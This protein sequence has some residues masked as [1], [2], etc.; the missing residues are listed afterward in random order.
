MLVARHERH[1]RLRL[2]M[3]ELRLTVRR[4]LSARTFAITAALTVGLAVGVNG[5]IYSAVRG[6]IV[7]PLPFR[8]ADRLVWIYGRARAAGAALEK[9][10][11]VEVNSLARQVSSFESVAVIGDRGF[12]RRD[13]ERRTRWTGIW[14]TPSLSAVL[15]IRPELGRTFDTDDAHPDVRLMMLG[16]ERWQRDFG[17]DPGIIGR[18]IRFLDNHEFTV[19]GILPRGLEFPFGR[20][21]QS[22][23]GSG[24]TL[25]VQDFWIVGQDSDVLPGGAAIARVGPD[26]TVAAARTEAAA[27]GTALAVAEPGSQAGRSLEPVSVRDQALG[28]V[29]P[30]LRLAQAF[31]AL[32]LLLACAN[33]INLTL[34]RSSARER[35]LGVRAA[36]GAGRR[37]IV[38]TVVAEVLLVTVAGAA[39]GLGVTVFAP[40][41]LRLLA[42]SAV[43]MIEHVTVD[44]AVV[45]FTVGVA[46]AVAL[47]VAVIP[48]AL[49]VRGNLHATL[50]SGGRTHTTDRRRARLHAGLVVSQVALALVLSVGAALIV[51]SFRRLMAVDAGYDPSGVIAADVTLHDHPQGRE[52]YRQLHARLAAVPGVEAVGMIQS[53]PLTGKWMF[54]DPFAVVGRPGDPGAAPPVSG[55]FIAFDYFEA[56]HTPVVLGRAFTPDEY[57]GDDAPALIINETAARRFFPNASPLGESAFLAGKARRIVGVVKDMRDVRLDTPADAQWFQPL[58]FDGTQLVIRTSGRAAD[59]VATIRRELAAADSRFEINSVQPLDDIV[60]TTVVERRMAMRLL[61]TLAA[62]ALAL[63]S[64]GLYGVLSFNVA[65]REREFGV[66]SALGAPRR[67]LLTMVLRAGLGMALAGTVAGVLLS[68]WVTGVLRG[69][70]FEVSPTEPRTISIIALLLLVV[71]AAASL[72]PAARAAGADPMRALRAD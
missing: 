34:L 71:A 67:A 39:I 35:E 49:A 48:A 21:P 58:L 46:T 5:M 70:L 19:V 69:L 16:Y 61:A 14:V 27:V 44:W 23:N 29:R 56:M 6:L 20:M 41:G 47:V 59:M 62:L 38:T 26:A 7:H 50:L 68:L 43:P 55:S 63:A 1:P 13:G 15:G 57:L 10:N 28:L 32:M 31:A 53:T 52:F 22:G 42:A 9:P 4:L 30:G 54:A 11:E 45:A 3:N 66:R 60:A 40:L 65:R 25:G 17:G 8:D 64:V 18:P 33:L 51:E 12:V 24:F 72:I 36:L 37:R 2:S